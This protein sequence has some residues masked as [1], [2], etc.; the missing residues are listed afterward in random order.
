M[1]EAKCELRM[2]G[3]QGWL[4]EWIAFRFSFGDLDHQRCETDLE[5]KRSHLDIA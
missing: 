2:R 5:L 3:I 4:P 1:G